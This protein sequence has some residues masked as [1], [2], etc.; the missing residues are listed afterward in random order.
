M[1]TTWA[2]CSVLEIGTGMLDPA[3]A[4]EFVSIPFW[5]H[6]LF[7]GPCSRPEPRAPGHWYQLRYLD[8]LAMNVFATRTRGAGASRSR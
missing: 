6:A 1:D 3:T 5:R 7:V 4:I 2:H 8:A